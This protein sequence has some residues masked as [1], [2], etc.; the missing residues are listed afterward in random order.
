MSIADTYGSLEKCPAITRG[1][2]FRVSDFL[3]KKRQNKLRWTIFS[4]DTSKQ[5]I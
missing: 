3:G 4:Y 5:H 1:P 2:L